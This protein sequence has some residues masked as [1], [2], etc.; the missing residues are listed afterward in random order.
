VA[1]AELNGITMSG[2]MAANLGEILKAI[3]GALVADSIASLFKITRASVRAANEALAFDITALSA[4]SITNV[5]DIAFSTS[6]AAKGAVS[7]HRLEDTLGVL[8]GE[9]SASIDERAI[10]VDGALRWGRSLGSR[11]SGCGSGCGGWG[12]TANICRALDSGSGALLCGIAVT[13]GRTANEVVGAKLVGR[14][15]SVEAGAV[16]GGITNSSGVAADLCI[17]L[18]LV[19]R[20][21]IVDTIASLLPIAGTSIRAADVSNLLFVLTDGSDTIASILNIASS[22][23][24]TA[25]GSSG[26][27]VDQRTL[28]TLANMVSTVAAL[29]TVRVLSALGDLRAGGGGGKSLRG[30]SGRWGTS[31]IGRALSRVTIACLSGVTG[32][33]GR[34]ARGSG[35]LYRI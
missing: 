29:S 15:R 11:T 13:S 17:V 5:V 35:G 8:A 3:C 21:L 25:S 30:G 27:E 4:H 16:L 31:G 1:S 28:A 6:S 7:S 24:S 33:S 9:V 20:A 23:S 34:T 14:A 22:S 10:T 18:E 12:R 2:S 26:L 19:S 32:A